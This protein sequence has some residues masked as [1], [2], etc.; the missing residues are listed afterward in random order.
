MAYGI[1]IKTDDGRDL[2]AML[3]PMF[4]LDYIIGIAS[5]S[6]TYPSTKGLTLKVMVNSIGPY[7]AT[8]RPSV[9]IS[10]NTV[11]WNQVPIQSPIIIYL[12]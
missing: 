6:R 5:G 10:G 3:S 7:G 4:V 2:I 8:A 1:Q 11:S 12:G 9:T